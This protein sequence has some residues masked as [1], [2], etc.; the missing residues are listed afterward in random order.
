MSIDDVSDLKARVT[1]LEAIV[2]Q[3][4]VQ[5]IMLVEDRR[6]WVEQGREA[7]EKMIANSDPSD[8]A[9]DLMTAHADRLFAMLR[10]NAERL[11][12]FRLSGPS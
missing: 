7:V 1:D 9:F 6:A 11:P 10:D 12:P 5:S 2:A 3:A 4:F 8:D